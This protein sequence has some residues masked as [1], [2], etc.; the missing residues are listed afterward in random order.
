MFKL[1][2]F[3]HKP[4]ILVALGAGRFFNSCDLTRHAADYNRTGLV[5]EIP[6]DE[7]LEE[8]KAFREEVVNCLSSNHPHLLNGDN[9]SPKDHK[10]INLS[11]KLSV[12]GPQ[13]FPKS[14][15]LL[16]YGRGF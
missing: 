8:G 4:G 10:L 5:L 13:K 2:A 7:I 15:P 3:C 14:F 6:A 1:L 16:L 9:G 12:L 11:Q